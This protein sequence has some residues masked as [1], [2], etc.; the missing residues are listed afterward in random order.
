ML[1]QLRLCITKTVCV[2]GIRVCIS[3]KTLCGFFFMIAKL[4]T[5]QND[6][7]KVYLYS[8]FCTL[9][10]FLSYMDIQGCLSPRLIHVLLFM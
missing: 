6:L 3:L 10:N 7:K 5:G 8:F 2:K 1:C 9:F 4:V